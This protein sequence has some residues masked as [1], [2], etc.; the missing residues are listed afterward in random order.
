MARTHKKK[1]DKKETNLGGPACWLDQVS[2]C[3]PAYG[4]NDAV[5]KVPHI[6]WRLN[7]ICQNMSDILFRYS[8]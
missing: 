2:Q 3:R 4:S 6:S 8:R 1:R 7:F 5:I